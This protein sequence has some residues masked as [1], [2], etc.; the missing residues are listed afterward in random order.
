MASHSHLCSSA[1]SSKP[2]VA[3]LGATGLQGGGVVKF[4]LEDGGF[5]IRAL[6]SNPDSDR[7]KGTLY[8]SRDSN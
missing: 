5:R 7:A 8:L 6:T 2:L 4:L 3:V 1:M